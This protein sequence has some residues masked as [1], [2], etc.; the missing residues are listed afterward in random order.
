MEDFSTRSFRVAPRFTQGPNGGPKGIRTPDL[1]AA[2][3]PA[4]NGVLTS[5]NAGRQ[6]A[7]AALLS[8]ELPPEPRH[9][10]A[11][12]HLVDQALAH[13]SAADGRATR[14]RRAGTP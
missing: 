2:S 4:L 3:H 1:L 12:D 7:E 8:A 5:E 6:R 9:D 14:R 10:P 11:T 13:P